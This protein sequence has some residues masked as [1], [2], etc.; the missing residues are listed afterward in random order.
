MGRSFSIAFRF[1]N[2]A[3]I[4][5]QIQFKTRFDFDAVVANRKQNLSLNFKP[6][7]HQFVDEAR[8]IDRFE[9]AWTKV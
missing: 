9:Q 6:L 4:D 7:P 2:Y 8:F 5:K 1:N 3:S